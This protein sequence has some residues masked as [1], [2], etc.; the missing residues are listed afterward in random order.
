[1]YSVFIDYGK[2]E[3]VVDAQGQL[4]MSISRLEHDT[5][6]VAKAAVEDV[7]SATLIRRGWKYTCDTPGSLWL[8]HKR[9]TTTHGTEYDALV[10]S[11]TALHMEK[12][13]K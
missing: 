6:Y 10:D 2:Y 4:K 1:M 5:L 8:W 9:V 12:W 3:F 7:I 13:L 11:T